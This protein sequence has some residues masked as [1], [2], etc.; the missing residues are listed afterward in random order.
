MKTTNKAI[1]L[2]TFILCCFSIQASAREWFVSPKGRDEYDGTMEK[3]FYSIQK[4]CMMAQAGDIVTIREGIY[5]IEE[6]VRPQRSGS[7]DNWITYRAFP[8]EKVI[9]DGS[10]LTHVKR[11]GDLIP[12]SSL[13]EGLVQI[14]N[15]SYIKWQ[16]ISVQNSY[17][18]GFI[19]RGGSESTFDPARKSPTEKIVLENCSSNRSYNS[20]IAL[21]YSDYVLV[22]RC[23]VIGANDID[24]RVKSV[25]P[26]GEAPHEAISICGARHFEVSYNQVH[27]CHKEGIDCKEVSRY[28]KVHHNIVWN[29]PRQAYYVDAWFGTLEDIELYENFSRDCFWGFAISVEG[30]NADLHNIR[31]HHNVICNTTA[32]GL[33]FGMWGGNNLR[34]DIYIYNNTFYHCGSPNVYSGGVGS[35]D[36]LSQNFQ[37]VYIYRNICDKGWDYEFGF[38]EKPESIATNMKVKNFVAKENL[39]EGTKFRLSRKGQFD[40]MLVEYLPEGN[41]IGNVLYRDEKNFDFVPEKAPKVK[42]EKVNW[43]YAPSDW[44]GALPPIEQF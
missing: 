37:N 33:L 28:G 6:Q 8:G 22:T 14:E 17:A 16:D 4:A 31:F 9:I 19:V 29:I 25:R 20:G 38:N 21:W 43:K 32:S 30:K 1:T 15:V 36:I 26:G 2:V 42:K 5:Y 11:N 27:D 10:Y 18:A 44:Y 13:H 24:F 12:F 34:K 40:A 23:E 39:V 3:P 41:K 35:I 7:L